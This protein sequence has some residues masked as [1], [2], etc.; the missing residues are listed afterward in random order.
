MSRVYARC[1]RL[2]EL[3]D[4][5]D[6]CEGRI[7]ATDGVEGRRALVLCLR[8]AADR[9]LTQDVGVLARGMQDDEEEVPRHAEVDQEV[10]VQPDSI[11]GHE[12]LLAHD[13]ANE[14]VVRA[15]RKSVTSEDKY[16]SYVPDRRNEEE[17]R[18]DN[19][20]TNKGSALL[21]REPVRSLRYIHCH[22]PG[23]LG[24]KRTHT[25]DFKP[26]DDG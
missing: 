11:R 24:K 26:K 10:N 18:L 16:T 9:V 23:R 12:R 13:H 4:E 6:G 5:D 20:T 3:D 21:T 7:N 8:A 1:E 25:G 19:R 17:E 2:T 14:A 22:S 15:K